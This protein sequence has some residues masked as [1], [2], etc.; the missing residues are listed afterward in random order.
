[1]NQAIAEHKIIIGMTK[2]QCVE[3]WGYPER[4]NRTVAARGKHEQ[5]IYGDTYVY[6]DNGVL[7]SWQDSFGR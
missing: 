7:T 3:A 4:L 2:K 6:F 5:W 1:M